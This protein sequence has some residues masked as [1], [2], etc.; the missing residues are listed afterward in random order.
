MEK[1]AIQES[2]AKVAREA[3]HTVNHL[4]QEARSVGNAI[5]GEETGAAF[6]AAGTAAVLSLGLVAGGFGLAAAKADKKSKEFYKK[7]D[8]YGGLGVP[9]DDE[10]RV[11]TNVGFG[12]WKKADLLTE[13]GLTIPSADVIAKHVAHN[14]DKAIQRAFED[15]T[16]IWNVF[17]FSKQLVKNRVAFGIRGNYPPRIELSFDEFNLDMFSE[18]NGLSQEDFRKLSDKLESKGAYLTASGSSLRQSG[19]FNLTGSFSGLQAAQK[20]LNSRPYKE[21]EV[22]NPLRKRLE[23]ELTKDTLFG[24]SMPK[25]EVS[26]E[27]LSALSAEE[28]ESVKELLQKHGISVQSNSDGG[29]TLIGD[30]DSLRSFLGDASFNHGSAD[31]VRAEAVSRFDGLR[32]GIRAYLKS[33]VMTEFTRDF[34]SLKR[35]LSA[36]DSIKFNVAN[37][38]CIIQ[39]DHG[40]EDIVQVLMAANRLPDSWDKG[41][42]KDLCDWAKN[43]NNALDAT[44]NASFIYGERQGATGVQRTLYTRVVNEE[45][46]ASAEVAKDQLLFMDA[47]KK[48]F[49]THLRDEELARESAKMTNEFQQKS[50][51]KSQELINA[52]SQSGAAGVTL[53][54]EQIDRLGTAFAEALQRGT[55]R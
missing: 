39:T 45:L 34:V 44:H 33:D 5:G 28:I 41:I 46:S 48:S 23:A 50:L 10:C 54:N 18:K 52:I 29:L 37:G 32:N 43:T 47:E 35:E 42:K 19:E 12:K 36:F 8:V 7:L 31:I 13:K 4:G 3:S 17:L 40:L 53:S 6:N 24:F 49:I 51:D 9:M 38:R 15:G 26:K 2:I 20:I 55:G 22:L 1:K 11:L 25:L 30:A 27:S 21:A 14:Q 16:S